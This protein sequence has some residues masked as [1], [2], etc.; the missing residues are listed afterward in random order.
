MRPKKKGAA[1]VKDG[2]K[3]SGRAR[4][5]ETLAHAPADVKV[6]FA[7][8]WM[9]AVRDHPW[10]TPADRRHVVLVADELALHADVEGRCFPGRRRIESR[11]GIHHDLIRHAKELLIDA[12]L[13]EISAFGRAHGHFYHLAVGL[14]RGPARRTTKPA[15]AVRPAGPRRG[16][17]RRTRTLQPNSPRGGERARSRAGTAPP[18]PEPSAPDQDPWTN[19]ARTA[20]DEY[21]TL[22]SVE[23]TARVLKAWAARKFSAETVRRILDAHRGRDILKIADLVEKHPDVA[24]GAPTSWQSPGQVAADEELERLERLKADVEGRG[25]AIP[26]DVKA[27]IADLRA[28]RSPGTRNTL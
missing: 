7:L 28:G 10:P 8:A 26:S 13:L 5:G 3:Q 11:S 12:G 24:G 17:A 9:Q 6:F 20:Q 4:V 27:Q 21:C 16:P 23:Q 2:A 18:P 1:R 19:A 25:R 14:G 15:V 22:G